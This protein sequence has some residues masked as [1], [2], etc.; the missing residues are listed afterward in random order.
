MPSLDGGDLDTCV[1]QVRENLERLLPYVKA[2]YAV[3]SPGPT[4][5]F[6]L[7]QEYPEL[8]K[9]DEARE[10]AA[11]VRDLGEYIIELKK[12]GKLDLD[13]GGP[14]D[15]RPQKVAYHF[16]CHLKVQKIGYKGRDVLRLIPGTEVAL[17]DNCCGMDGT[18]GMKKEF[19]QLS[20]KVAEKAATAVAE[21]KVA[22]AEA[23]PAIAFRVSSDCPLAAIQLKQTTGE[24]VVHPILLLRDAYRRADAR[25]FSEAATEPPQGG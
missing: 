10:V 11:A 12:Q 17:V 1:G 22:T 9:T 19:F 4:C 7:R 15:V 25:R 21:V 23:T 14:A 6:M 24:E 13:F 8:L 18:W 5:T 3:V 16:P 20:V 2:G